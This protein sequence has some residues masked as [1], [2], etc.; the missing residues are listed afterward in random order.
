VVTMATMFQDLFKA[1]FVFIIMFGSIQDVS[2]LVEQ[3]LRVSYSHKNK[4]N[5][6]HKP[7]SENECFS[8]SVERLH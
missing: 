1:A 5:P 6:S 8:S 3:T 2:K 7:M 4:E